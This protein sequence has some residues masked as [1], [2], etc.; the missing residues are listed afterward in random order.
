LESSILEQ[1]VYGKGI[2]VDTLIWSSRLISMHLV[3]YKYLVN[4]FSCH[5]L[6]L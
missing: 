1:I 6:Q 2:S 3:G 4:S 5:C